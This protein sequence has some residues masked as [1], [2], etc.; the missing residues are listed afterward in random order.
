VRRAAPLVLASMLAS[1]V[2]AAQTDKTLAKEAYDRGMQAHARGDFKRAAEDFARADALAPSPVALQ[3]A[4][5]AAVDADDPVLGAEL[6]ERSKRETPT[7][8]LV[9]SIA[10][11][12][13]KLGGR[14]G[15]VRVKCPS[16]ARCASQLDGA[17]FEPARGIWMRPGPHTLVMDV[18]GT[19][20]T[21]SVEVRAGEQLEVVPARAAAPLPATA[22]P[23]ASGASPQAPAGAPREALPATEARAKPLPPIVFFVGAGVTVVLAGAAT[24]YGLTAKSKHDDFVGA[25]CNVVVTGSCQGLKDDGESAQSFAN[26][27]FV[28]TAVAGVATVVIGAL[29]TDWSHAAKTGRAP[30]VVPVPGGIAAGYGLRF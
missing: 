11:A 3:A 25:A 29:F 5:D 21:R 17:P 20:D 18:D 12:T 24:F 22:P 4:L 7:G 27:G 9:P 8:A 13:K 23:A 19:P 28:G 1:G 6:L 14:A 15:R 16:G 10:A 26:I 30:V 2:A